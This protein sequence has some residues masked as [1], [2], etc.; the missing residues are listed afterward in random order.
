[1]ISSK[2]LIAFILPISMWAQYKYLNGYSKFGL[3]IQDSTWYYTRYPEALKVYANCNAFMGC[4]KACPEEALIAMLS[5]N[6]HVW[7]SQNYQEE[8]RN[9]SSKS[10]NIDS[11]KTIKPYAIPLLKITFAAAGVE[12]A[13]LKYQYTSNDGKV[14]SSCSLMFK[15]KEKWIV[16]NPKSRRA[17]WLSHTMFSYFSIDAL[18]AILTNQKTGIQGFDS[19]L[20][21][22][23]DGGALDVAKLLSTYAKLRDIAVKEENKK[24][25]V[26][27][28]KIMNPIQKTTAYQTIKIRN[29]LASS[30]TINFKEFEATAI[31]VTYVKQFM[32]QIMYL[33]EPDRLGKSFVD[34]EL[35]VLLINV[36]ETKIDRIVP[37]FRYNFYANNSDYTILRYHKKESEG[38]KIVTKLLRKEDRLWVP[39][40]PDTPDI[41]TIFQFFSTI[42]R[43]FYEE[44]T[45][46]YSQDATIASI[47]HQVINKLDVMDIEKLNRLI[48][49]NRSEL[50]SYTNE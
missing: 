25:L 46:R 38:L 48:Q 29:T 23:H 40:V 36:E 35:D 28:Y 27:P 50:T 10:K 5:T 24:I 30:Q 1:M 14:Y 42:K 34:K 18:D 45:K 37:V 44:V 13:L 11:L 22:F 4:K 15:E 31:P 21:K 19:I 47:R 43:S 26:E 16:L 2:A 20:Q 3:S 12:Y 9:N 49:E 7:D 17:L 33:Y 8:V 6:D 32:D 39:I 41:K